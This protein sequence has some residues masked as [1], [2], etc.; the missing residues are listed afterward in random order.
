MSLRFRTVSLRETGTD[1]FTRK[2]KF[3][4]IRRTRSGLVG[5]KGAAGEA[6]QRRTADNHRAIPRAPGPSLSTSRNTDCPA[7]E[8]R[9][10]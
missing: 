2:D 5:E 6:K 3:V 4:P 1:R 8:Y 9:T 10:P 7:I